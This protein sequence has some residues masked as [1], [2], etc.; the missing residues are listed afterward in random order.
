[1]GHGVLLFDTVVAALSR[2]GGVTDGQPVGHGGEPGD[3]L[4]ELGG[5]IRDNPHAFLGAYIDDRGV[6]VVVLN[7]RADARWGDEAVAVGLGSGVKV[8]VDRAARDG[9]ALEQVRAAVT[10]ALLS[11]PSGSFEISV[12]P[13]TATV[14]VRSMVSPDVEDG[15]R[16]QFGD[17]VSFE[18][19]HVRR[20]LGRVAIRPAQSA[21]PAED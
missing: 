8:T 3:E 19:G 17:S 14:E 2:G 15:L 20:G 12:S 9:A 11:L 13:R 5:F 21:E 1:M 10:A 16:T 18:R 6:Y 7:A 4:A